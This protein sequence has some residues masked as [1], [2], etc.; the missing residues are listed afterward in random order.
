MRE[1][2]KEEEEIVE[3]A[4]K[5]MKLKIIMSHEISQTQKNREPRPAQVSPENLSLVAS[6]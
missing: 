5:W 2:R 6:D 3:F 4:R 1:M